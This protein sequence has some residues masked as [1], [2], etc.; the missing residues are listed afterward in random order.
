[1]A[2]AVE[3]PYRKLVQAVFTSIAAARVAPSAICTPEALLGTASSLLQPPYTMRSTS[4]ASSPAQARA[5]AE[6]MVAIS[7]A[8]MCD[9]RRSFMPVR[10]VI[11]SSEVSRNVERSSLERTEGGSASPQPVIAAWRAGVI[12]RVG[13]TFVMGRWIG[14]EPLRVGGDPADCWEN[15]RVVAGRPQERALNIR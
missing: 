11:H 2:V 15:A 12:A 5:R 6:A 4:P 9:T 8:E 3:S 14:G 13:K 7:I 1:M 10:C